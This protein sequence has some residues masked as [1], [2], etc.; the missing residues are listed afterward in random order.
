LLAIGT[1]GCGEVVRDEETLGTRSDAIFDGQLD[2][3]IQDPKVAPVARIGFTKNGAGRICSATLIS[4]TQ[5]LTAAHCAC[6]QGQALPNTAYTEVFFPPFT[7]IHGV[8]VAN[9]EL[10]PLA[11]QACQ[12]GVARRDH[13]LAILTLSDPVPETAVPIVPRIA[14]GNLA[15]QQKK[16][17]LS[18]NGW[19]VGYG[20]SSGY[21]C[22]DI[23]GQAVAVSFF[24]AIALLDPPQFGHPASSGDRRVGYSPYTGA[25]WDTCGKVD[26]ECQPDMVWQTTDS[27]A[28]A[29]PGPGDSG[30]P[31]WK[32]QSEFGQ[33]GWVIAGVLSGHVDL[34]GYAD[35]CRWFRWSPTGASGGTPSNQ[36]WILGQLGGDGDGDLVPDSTDNCPPARCPGD[37]M[38]CA[39]PAQEDS[40]GDGVGDAC[41]NCNP[42]DCLN[43]QSFACSF[44]PGQN[45]IDQDGRGDVCDLCPTLDV[46]TKDEDGDGVGD[47]CD[48]CPCVYSPRGLCDAAC[49]SEVCA[50][51]SSILQSCPVQHD[52]DEDGIPDACDSCAFPD[53]GTNTNELAEE[54]EGWPKEVDV[55]DPVPLVRLP[56]QTTNKL[57][58]TDWL[59]LV[60][61]DGDGIDDLHDLKATRWLGIE[62]ESDPLWSFDGHRP[63]TLRHCDCFSPAGERFNL[64]KCIQENCSLDFPT[65]NTD[66]KVMEIQ[67]KPMI[68]AGAGPG[69]F[70]GPVVQGGT[71]GFTS[72]DA[73]ALT[74]FSTNVSYSAGLQWGWREDLSTGRVGGLGDCS[75]G[76]D[77]CETHGIVYTGVLGAWTGSFRDTFAN[78]RD[79]FRMIDTPNVVVEKPHPP[80]PIPESCHF[81]DC[82]RWQ[83]PGLIVSN[84][85]PTDFMHKFDGPVVLVAA[86]NT[87]H[88]LTLE[89]RALDITAEVGPGVRALIE[90][91]SQ[92]WLAPI[93]S[94]KLIRRYVQQ[95]AQAVTIP[96]SWS[97]QPMSFSVTMS[98][99]GLIGGVRDVRLDEATLMT[100]SAQ[101]SPGYTLLPPAPMN[102]VRALHSALENS[103][104]VAGGAGEDGQPQQMVWRFDLG[105]REWRAL[106][107]GGSH[108][109]GHLLEIA[110]DPLRRELFVLDLDLSGPIAQ[111]PKTVRLVRYALRSGKSTLLGSWKRSSGVLYQVT[112]LGGGKLVVSGGSKSQLEACGVQA[113]ATS[114]LPLGRVVHSGQILGQTVMGDEH[115][116]AAVRTKSGYRRVEIGPFKG[117]GTCTFLAPPSASAVAGPSG[118]G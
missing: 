17:T 111:P 88:A 114:L 37:P 77:A 59:N 86:E 91:D 95:P 23:V 62:Q 93:E 64:E 12:H 22:A 63:Y 92:L 34:V 70:A 74:R 87:V 36:D 117:K 79:V 84:P 20:R 97:A 90:D 29:V 103:V 96:R 35:K 30:G 60:P 80:F 42:E 21:E 27:L 115:P 50:E 99:T 43:P 1:W 54:R 112:A 6:G 81:G 14:F 71:S 33:P 57:T 83:D 89:G 38:A 105:T 32:Y 39:N 56:I 118:G 5:L 28:G 40:D 107:L 24:G 116:F 98:S 85:N 25:V 49:P 76:K 61:G 13:D 73:N 108:A 110:Y 69:P 4:R 9:V 109:I 58:L 10:H 41:D 78:L 75:A 113:T 55:C 18:S 94:R 11:L 47:A 46:F 82:L 101:L 72:V 31:L 52:A 7:E 3:T 48:G 19:I 2:M 68:Y 26:W 106:G 44:N 8:P 66:F 65:V 67:R 102:G 104:L 15:E 51:S 53:D 45:D 16:Y 100:S